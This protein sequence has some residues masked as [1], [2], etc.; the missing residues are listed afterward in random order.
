MGQRKREEE[1]KGEEHKSGGWEEE[2]W[3]LWKPG[4]ACISQDMLC[5][6]PV[7]NNKS[8]CLPQQ[9]FIA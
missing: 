6:A 4:K 7:T 2:E 9:R 3:V 5:Y 8:Q 1:P